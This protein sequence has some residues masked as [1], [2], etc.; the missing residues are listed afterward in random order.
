MKSLQVL[1]IIM[2]MGVSTP[3]HTQINIPS[4]SPAGSVSSV[5]GLTEVSINYHRPKLRG[6]K[7]FGA[8][9][10]ALLPYGKLWRTGAG[11]GTILSLSER[12]TIA[13][14]TIEAG[15]YLILTI[16]DKE[17]WTFILYSD[18]EIDGAN[19]EPNYKKENEVLKI[20][21]Q[22]IQLEKEVQSL[23][24]QITDISNDNKTANIAF[25]WSNVAFKIPFTVTFDNEVME[26]I[27]RKTVVE[28]INYIRAAQY[29][30]AY[31]KDLE[32][33]L[34][35][36]NSYLEMD[37]HDTHFWYMYLKAQILAKLGRQEEAIET[38][39]KS[40][41][42]ARKSPRGDLGYIKRNEA[43]IASFK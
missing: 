38:A 22:S 27:E 39:E 5:V 29:Y 33:A 19:L 2:V 20:K 21:A 9:E 28:P 35:W 32:Q 23:T 41:A 17:E 24:F 10:E 4:A 42:L 6:R 7:I 40:I 25:S 31:D 1:L 37:G 18:L 34:S 43:I 3:V 30:Y 13:E 8:G 36:V 26:A 14:Q 12:V 11:D 15:Q 16:P